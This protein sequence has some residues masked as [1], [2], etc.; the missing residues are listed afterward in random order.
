MFAQ[1]EFVAMRPLG[2]DEGGEADTLELHA[3]A[4]GVERV[5]GALEQERKKKGQAAKL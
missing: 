4:D 3:G 5:Q 2:A 1:D